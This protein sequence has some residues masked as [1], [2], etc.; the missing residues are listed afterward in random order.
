MTDE[1]AGLEPNQ[2]SGALMGLSTTRGSSM[3]GTSP[4]SQTI[5]VRPGGDFAEPPAGQGPACDVRGRIRSA[6]HAA[7]SY[8]AE[9]G[10]GMNVKG[11]RLLS[12]GAAAV[13]AFTGAEQGLAAAGVAFLALT[14]GERLF[15][16]LAEALASGPAQP[17]VP[18][19]ISGLGFSG[20]NAPV[21]DSGDSGSASS[22]SS[23][24]PVNLP[25]HHE[26]QQDVPLQ[27]GVGRELDP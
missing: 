23:S 19:L 1:L 15:N 12:L 20:V 18:A 21:D 26:P 11:M 13:C 9:R 6:L 17:S 5:A 14:F 10:I 2:G 22:A 8:L 3:N 16:R 4:L 27:K 25:S 24:S 7:T